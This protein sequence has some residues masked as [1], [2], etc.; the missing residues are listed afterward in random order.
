LKDASA[1]TITPQKSP[2]SS[3]H[4]AE[5]TALAAI[6]SLVADRDSLRNYINFQARE[7]AEQRATIIALQ[8]RIA[9]MRQHYIELATQVLSQLER[10]DESTRHETKKDFV[11]NLTKHSAGHEDANFLSLVQRL[12]PLNGSTDLDR[13]KF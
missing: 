9:V 7:L 11:S 4:E 1:V 12:A 5:T 2:H 8:E 13:N 10:F 3:N 6:Q